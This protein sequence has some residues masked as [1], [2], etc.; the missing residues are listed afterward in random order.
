MAHTDEGAP[1]MGNLHRSYRLDE[2]LLADVEAYAK[3]HDLKA[4]EAVSRLLEAALQADEAGGEE[5]SGETPSSATEAAIK[6]L[7]AQLEAK[8]EQI[9]AALTVAGQ[10]QAISHLALE[11]PHE[12]DEGE[13]AVVAEEAQDEENGADRNN[14]QNTQP[15]AHSSLSSAERARDAALR[16]EEAATARVVA[17]EKREAELLQ[18]LDALE[19]EQGERAKRGGLGRR[20]RQLFNGR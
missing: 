1:H 19:A 12:P 9:R 15:P 5:Q 16:D 14:N 8:D 3:A 10:A 13:A 20:F 17:L 6:A 2:G 4:S 11:A 18:R 7:T